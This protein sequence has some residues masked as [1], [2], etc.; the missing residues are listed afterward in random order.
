MPVKIIC[1]CPDCLSR[2]IPILSPNPGRPNFN[3][4]QNR[5]LIKKCKHLFAAARYLGLELVD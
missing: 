3:F 2:T 4:G 5:P 1:N